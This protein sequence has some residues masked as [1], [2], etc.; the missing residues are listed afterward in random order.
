MTNNTNSFYS[1]TI[2]EPLFGYAA[3]VLFI[4]CKI[5]NTFTTVPSLRSFS[6]KVVEFIEDAESIDKEDFM[7]SLCEE[8]IEVEEANIF[9]EDLILI[10]SQTIQST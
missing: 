4:I 2:D 10:T 1:V 6:F 9:M 7:H 3:R 5:Y 8:G